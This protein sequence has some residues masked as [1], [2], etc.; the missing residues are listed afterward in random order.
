[1]ISLLL[2]L[3]SCGDP[4]GPSQ[5]EEVE[6]LLQRLDAMSRRLDSIEEALARAEAEEPP[7]RLPLAD[8]SDPTQP[9]SSESTGTLRVDLRP[10]GVMI[11]DRLLSRQEAAEHFRTTALEAPGTRLVVLASPDVPHADVVALLD[12]A[13]EAGLRDVAMSA[14][15]HG[16]GDGEP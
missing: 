12:L 13:R 2:G 9:P 10:T 11:D 7:D 4:P 8:L 16:E 3:G 5:A 15:V 6:A 14:R 1:M